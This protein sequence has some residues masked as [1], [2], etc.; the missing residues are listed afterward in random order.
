MSKQ[1]QKIQAAASQ[2]VAVVLRLPAG[3][4]PNFAES[5][6][7]KYV[8]SEVLTEHIGTN[9]NVT[10]LRSTTGKGIKAAMPAIMADG[11]QVETYPNITIGIV[12][13]TKAVSKV[14]AVAAKPML[15]SND[16]AQAAINEAMT[17]ALISITDKL[18]AIEKKL[19]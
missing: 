13:S 14:A 3:N 8:M 18:A 5:F 2:L 19:K 16:N 4:L 15:V 7:D 1:G 17:D 12:G 10:S 9:G 11:S 6:K